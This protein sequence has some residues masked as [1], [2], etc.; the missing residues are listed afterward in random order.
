MPS[1]SRGTVAQIQGEEMRS[2]CYTLA[3][4]EEALLAL[5]RRGIS[6]RAHAPAHD[7]ETGK[8]PVIHLLL[9]RRRIL[10]ARPRHVG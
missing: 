10:A 6:L 1:L 9:G 5:E 8:L 3:D 4:M 2:L 7:P